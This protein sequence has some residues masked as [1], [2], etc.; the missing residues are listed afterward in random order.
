M[1][2]SHHSTV[3]CWSHV[4]VGSVLFG[5]QRQL[6]RSSTSTYVVV[7]IATGTVIEGREWRVLI[8]F[9]WFLPIIGLY[10]VPD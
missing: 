7:C 2:A 3:F 5:F 1:K 4:K 8:F 9:F 6:A 10:R